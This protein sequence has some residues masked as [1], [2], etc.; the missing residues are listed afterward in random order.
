MKPFKKYLQELE[1]EQWE[2]RKIE[3]I[4]NAL[5][6]LRKQNEN[7]DKILK[8]KTPQEYR[9][10]TKDLVAYGWK[11]LGDLEFKFMLHFGD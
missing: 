3:D 6:F 5:K 1:I 9:E 8:S 4:D 7:I 11:N 10:I 2:N